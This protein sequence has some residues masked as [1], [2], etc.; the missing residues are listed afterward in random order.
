[1]HFCPLHNENVWFGYTS[2]ETSSYFE[3]SFSSFYGEKKVQAVI[4]VAVP[5]DGNKSDI[6]DGGDES[7]WSIESEVEEKVIEIETEEDTEESD[8]SESEDEATGSATNGGK[9]KA[10]AKGKKANLSWSK[11]EWA[12]PNESSFDEVP[13]RLNENENFSPSTSPMQFF[14]LFCNDEFF[15]NCRSIKLV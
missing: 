12:L 11:G 4:P 3:I 1:M 6:G 8:S 9:P 7:D 13:L 14:E 2:P 10:K 5:V 15:V